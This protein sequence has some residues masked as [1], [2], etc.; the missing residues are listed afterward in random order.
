MNKCRQIKEIL[1][2]SVDLS[3]LTA[4][5]MKHLEGCH[6]CAGTLD[7]LQELDR[8]LR[9]VTIRPL[10]SSEAAGFQATLDEKIDVY[11]S[12]SHKGYRT[13]LRY[14][15]LSTAVALLLFLVFANRLQLPGF[16]FGP[17]FQVASNLDSAIEALVNEEAAAYS[18]NDLG[19]DES[20][21]RVIVSD[22]IRS[23][24]YNTGDMLLGDLS[25]EELEYIRN[26]F[27]TE[28]IL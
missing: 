28:D 19:I 13:A 17:E 12:R 3:R 20:Y 27:K 1:L 14:G 25:S 5:E 22:Y 9:A 24:G 10:T 4:E 18:D 23:N 7:Q 26:N 8:A 15:V 21:L 11:Q 6:H 2:L 16:S